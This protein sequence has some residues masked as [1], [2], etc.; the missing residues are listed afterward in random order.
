MQDHKFLKYFVSNRSVAGE[1]FETEQY[2]ARKVFCFLNTI[3]EKVLPKLC[4][5]YLRQ[6]MLLWLFCKIAR[7]KLN[8]N[9]CIGFENSSKVNVIQSLEKIA[10][11]ILT[12]LSQHSSSS[13]HLI[14]KVAQHWDRIEDFVR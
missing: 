3:N 14:P 9:P 13:K 8:I 4:F 2:W 10:E 6:C 5:F 1:S 11:I 7:P 12:F